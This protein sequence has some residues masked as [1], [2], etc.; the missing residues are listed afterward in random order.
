MILGYNVTMIVL[1]CT[2]WYGELETTPNMDNHNLVSSINSYFV[3][4]YG[5]DIIFIL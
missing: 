3:T 1:Y 5:I 2:V 4:I